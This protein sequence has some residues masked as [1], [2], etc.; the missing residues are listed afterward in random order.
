MSPTFA[1][2]DAGIP[3][4]RSLFFRSASCF[5]K[6]FVTFAEQPLSNNMKDEKIKR[7]S[8]ILAFFLKHKLPNRVTIYFNAKEKDEDSWIVYPVREGMTLYHYYIP[9]DSLI[10][11]YDRIVVSE[12]SAD[13]LKQFPE[14]INELRIQRYPWPE[15]VLPYRANKASY[16]EIDSIVMVMTEYEIKPWGL[17]KKDIPSYDCLVFDG[18]KRNAVFSITDDEMRKEAYFFDPDNKY[19]D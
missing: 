17:Y 5:P 11:G 3:G 12:R 8:P 14:R 6:G 19:Q 10:D 2:V 4:G 13:Y 18:F 1:K 7:S 9:L 15:V 16:E